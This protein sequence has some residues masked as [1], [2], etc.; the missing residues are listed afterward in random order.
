MEKPLYIFSEC[1]GLYEVVDS[2]HNFKTNRIRLYPS[3]TMPDKEKIYPYLSPGELALIKLAYYLYNGYAENE[4]CPLE[5]FC[6]L[7]L[8]CNFLAMNAIDIRVPRQVIIIAIFP[9]FST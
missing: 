1:A 3:E 6:N 5:L 4:M 2:L 8:R 9:N 7:N